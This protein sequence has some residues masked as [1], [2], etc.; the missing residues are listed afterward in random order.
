M[1]FYWS[2]QT[3]PLGASSHVIA[4]MGS[5]RI[6]HMTSCIEN[7]H[8]SV[9]LMLAPTCVNITAWLHPILVILFGSEFG[10]ITWGLKQGSIYNGQ[11]SYNPARCT[12]CWCN[13][14]PTVEYL[15]HLIKHAI[16]SGAVSWLTFCP[17]SSLTLLGQ[18]LSA[19][20]R[21]THLFLLSLFIDGSQTQYM[22][23]WSMGNR[24]WGAHHLHLKK[25]WSPLWPA[26]SL[27]VAATCPTRYSLHTCTTAALICQLI[28][29]DYLFSTLLY[30]LPFWACPGFFIQTLS[31]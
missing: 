14:A 6:T 13:C 28:L 19:T 4:H 27:P 30:A 12:Y 26:R 22:A 3:D 15:T 11:I 16:I 25:E 20:W 7:V 1:K 17:C 10:I 23:Q 29:A 8:C 9:H 31:Q 24:V 18:F 5:S 21:V 2:S